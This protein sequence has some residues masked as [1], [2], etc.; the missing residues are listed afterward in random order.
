MTWDYS[1]PPPPRTREWQ[2]DLAPAWAVV[3]GEHPDF[4]GSHSWGR[5]QALTGGHGTGFEAE[6]L[7]LPNAGFEGATGP[8]KPAR[9]WPPPPT[10]EGKS[11]PP[12]PPTPPWVTRDGVPK[13]LPL[14]ACED[15]FV[16]CP[17]GSMWQQI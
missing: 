7:P 17:W 10:Q 9:L 12:L 13:G 8:A 2:A 3:V 15:S 4:T 6:A 11:V 5:R 14:S 1:T 16:H